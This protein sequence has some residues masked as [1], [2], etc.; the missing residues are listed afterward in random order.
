MA[1]I[2]IKRPGIARMRVSAVQSRFLT[3]RPCRF[4]A[5]TAY[6]ALHLVD[7]MLTTIAQ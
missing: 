1:P 6:N 4:V 7:A 5:A 3:G 2:T